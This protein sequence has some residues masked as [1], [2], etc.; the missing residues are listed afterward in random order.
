MQA[1]MAAAIAVDAFYAMIW[2]HVDLPP[3]IA[4]KWRAGRTARY[5]QV[6][7]VT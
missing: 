2:T 1:I 3:D 7:E 5:S 4:N 6:T